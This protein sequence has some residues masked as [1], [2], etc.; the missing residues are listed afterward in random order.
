MISLPWKNGCNDGRTDCS[1]VQPFL[2]LA[3]DISTASAARSSYRLAPDR[4]KE[5]CSLFELENYFR[6]LPERLLCSMN[7]VTCR[8]PAQ[9]LVLRKIYSLRHF[10]DRTD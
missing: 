4:P 10:R 1:S 7:F 2:H 6:F 3:V 5:T 8:I 9:L